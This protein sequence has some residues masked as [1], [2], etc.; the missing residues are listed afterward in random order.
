MADAEAW[1]RSGNHLLR[2]S[3]ITGAK[4]HD[5]SL[6]VYFVGSDKF[7]SLRG[8]DATALW[9]ELTATTRDLVEPPSQEGRQP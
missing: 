9:A 1:I 4:W 7:M 5:G 8:A 6:Y 2:R 3:T